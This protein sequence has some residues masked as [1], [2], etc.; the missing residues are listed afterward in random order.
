M[1]PVLSATRPCG[2]E[3]E[4]LSG[5]SLNWP[6]LGSNRPSTLAL[7]PVYQSEP[8]DAAS[9]SCGKVLAFG[10]SHSRMEAFAVWAWAG[11]ARKAAAVVMSGRSDLVT[12]VPPRLPQESPMAREAWLLT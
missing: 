4:V 3:P 2:P 10:R 7:K 11:T 8:S 12:M 5:Y 1:C 9:G 6:V